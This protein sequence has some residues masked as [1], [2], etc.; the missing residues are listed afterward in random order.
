M[1]ELCT[2]IYWALEKEIKSG[3][4][5]IYET[6]QLLVELWRKPCLSKYVEDTIVPTFQSHLVSQSE[7]FRES[8]THRVAAYAARLERVVSR[9]ELDASKEVIDNLK[10]MVLSYA[11]SPEH[12]S[13][14]AR[15]MSS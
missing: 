15:R 10:D 9:G 2:Q 12:A 7:H 3:A 8:A 13:Q 1:T 4:F 14:L 6:F 11:T 5:H